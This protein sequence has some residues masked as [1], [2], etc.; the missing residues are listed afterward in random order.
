MSKFRDFLA[1]LETSELSEFER[2][3]LIPG[4]IARIQFYK[5]CFE[6]LLPICNNPDNALLIDGAVRK[7]VAADTN[8]DPSVPTPQVGQ[9]YLLGIKKQIQD[10]WI[11]DLGKFLAEFPNAAAVHDQKDMLK[12]A[13]TAQALASAIVSAKTKLLS[14][15][16]RAFPTIINRGTKEQEYGI[17]KE[18][19]ILAYP[20]QG[21][22]V[23]M[24]SSA[25]SLIESF[26]NWRQNKMDV[27]KDYASFLIGQ[28]QHE[29]AMQ[30]GEKQ[31]QATKELNRFQIL[32]IVFTIV[33]TLTANELIEFFKQLAP[34]VKSWFN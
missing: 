9:Q 1:E 7:V 26:Q 14:F 4:T 25:S 19:E 20:F 33:L 13:Q 28:K 29:Y 15:S 34:V 8:I 17:P 11:K 5:D 10:Y 22:L 16:L 24:E 32:V 31:L 2:G 23:E 21:V 18:I 12:F 30:I 3:Y 27:R 6:K